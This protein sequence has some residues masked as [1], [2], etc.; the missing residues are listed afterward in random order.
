METVANIFLKSDKSFEINEIS[1]VPIVFNQNVYQYYLS[2]LSFSFLNCSPNIY[3]T[4]YLNYTI[5][6]LNDTTEEI[7]KT[8]SPGLYNTDDLINLLNSYFNISDS[9]TPPKQHQILT[10]SINPFDE[11]V[12][13]RFDSTEANSVLIKEILINN[14]YN[15]SLLSN[16]LFRFS[17]QTI[18]FTSTNELFVSDKAFRISTYNNVML[19]SA[20]I[21]GLVSLYGDDDGISTSSALYVISSAADPYSMIEYTAIQPVDFPLDNIPNLTNYQFKLYDEN[22]ND[23]KLLENATPDFS[24]KLAIKRKK[25]I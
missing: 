8:I 4:N 9:Q 14:T 6:Y 7:T 19:S 16:D 22:N 20:S 23:L 17:A 3:E 2:L 13:I 21:P 10:F 1:Q 11:M 12:E 18:N 24:V 15:N 5:T 25:R